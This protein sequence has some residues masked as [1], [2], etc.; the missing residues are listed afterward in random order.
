MQRSNELGRTIVKVAPRPGAVSN[1][2]E[3]RCASTIAFAIDNPTRYFDDEHAGYFR[4]LRRRA[5][6]FKGRTRSYDERFGCPL[7]AKLID[8]RAGRPKPVFPTTLSGSSVIVSS[9]SRVSGT[10]Y[11]STGAS[12]RRLID[13]TRSASLRS[14]LP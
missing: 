11:R 1:T 5:S 8:R 3:L 10:R 14:A 12:G 9:R 7:E 6:R 2:I 4:V 13:R